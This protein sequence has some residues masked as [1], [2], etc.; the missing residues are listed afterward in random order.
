[1]RTYDAGDSGSTSELVCPCGR[2][3]TCV[4]LLLHEI[5][6]RGQGAFAV[7]QRVRRGQLTLQPQPKDT[8]DDERS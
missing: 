8:T 3:F 6:K 4:K 2:R 5:E 1:M 7:A